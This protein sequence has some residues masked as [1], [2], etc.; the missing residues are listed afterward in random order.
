MKRQYASIR[1]KR[2]G[3]Q[4]TERKHADLIAAA[5]AD[6]LTLA[7]LVRRALDADLN[8]PANIRR[9]AAQTDKDTG[10]DTE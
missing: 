6:G 1:T 10:K 4:V 3:I 2:I 7:E 8:A 5:R 9:R